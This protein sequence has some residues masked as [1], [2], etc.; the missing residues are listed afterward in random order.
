MISMQM[1]KLAEILM[2]ENIIA[3]EQKETIKNLIEK[4]GVI[5]KSQVELKLLY[6]RGT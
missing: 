6:V 3:I 2:E 5:N 1:K 4:I